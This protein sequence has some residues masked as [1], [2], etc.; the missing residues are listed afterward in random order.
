MACKITNTTNYGWDK[1]KYLNYKY[2]V[3]RKLDNKEK[4]AFDFMQEYKTAIIQDDFELAKAIT[5]C[6][7]PLNYDT[8]DTHKHI[9][10]LN[11]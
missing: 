2:Y 7:K 11:S 9:K 8:A 6:L 4:T 5:E 1:K 10:Q 3:Q